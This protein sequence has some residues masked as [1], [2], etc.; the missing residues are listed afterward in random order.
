MQYEWL[1]LP[2]RQTESARSIALRKF[3]KPHWNLIFSPLE[4]DCILE[5][6]E[7]FADQ[8]KDKGSIYE[9]KGV[10]KESDYVAAMPYTEENGQAD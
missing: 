1:P 9:D 2:K 5:I 3:G 8:F 6:A 10:L 4:Q 7:A